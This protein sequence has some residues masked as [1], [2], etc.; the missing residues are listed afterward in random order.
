MKELKGTWNGRTSFIKSSKS[1]SGY[2]V[3]NTV[4]YPFNQHRTRMYES[5][6]NGVVINWTPV[7][8]IKN[9]VFD[10]LILKYENKD[11]NEKTIL[12]NEEK[13]ETR[14]KRKKIKE[15]ENEFI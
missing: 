8:D 1:K 3:V 2:F 7:I 14:A 15:A 6:L 5:D 13:I 10:K 12:D 4:I 9:D 11:N